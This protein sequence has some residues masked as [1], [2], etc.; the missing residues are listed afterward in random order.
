M[1]ITHRITK[2]VR[3]PTLSAAILAVMLAGSA[4]VALG[5]EIEDQAGPLVLKKQGS[6]FVGGETVFS[7]A[8]LA[9][10]L[11]PGQV[12]PTSGSMMVNQMYV[13]Y[14]IPEG[15]DHHVPV[16]MVHGATL[17]GKSWE[18]TPDGRMGW[19]D[20]FARRGRPV[21]IADQVSRGRSGFNQTR[22]NEVLLGIAAPSTLPNMFRL[23]R[24]FSWTVFRFGP[25]FGVPYPDTQFPV[26]AADEFAKQ[27]VPD[28]TFANF[29]WPNPTPT[30]TNM[31][32]LGRK[33]G[34]TILM[35]HSESSLY[36]TQAALIDPTGVRGII[37]L[38]TGCL[39]PLTPE[40]LAILKKIP[41][42]VM[43]GDLRG[44]TPQLPTAACAQEMT[45]VNGAGGDMTYISL[46]DLGMHGN[47]H[48]FMLDKNNLQI[49]DV[50][51]AWIDKHVEG[52]KEGAH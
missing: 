2:A 41:I 5:E 1:R 25:T 12:L 8:L 21:Y 36:P 29:D 6:F 42:L 26:E 32:A 23:G 52:T 24:E 40:Q 46:P 7:D 15:G 37:G 10:R 4:A 33:L 18:E 19:N 47:S 45:Q 17:T 3:H 20:Y 31:A 51:L 35:G 28:L 9:G 27:G 43:V 14:Q 49:A 50:I 39:A 34:G 16:V 13:Q 38:E 22:P 48:M 30:V 44:P 11:Y